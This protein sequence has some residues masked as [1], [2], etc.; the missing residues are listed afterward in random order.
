MAMFFGRSR[1]QKEED[2]AWPLRAWIGPMSFA[3]NSP[4]SRHMFLSL[5]MK[6][7]EN[8]HSTMSIIMFK[9]CQTLDYFIASVTDL[10]KKSWADTCLN[11]VKNSIYMYSVGHL[12]TDEL[13]G[14]GLL[15]C[16]KASVWIQRKYRILAI[17]VVAQAHEQ[18]PILSLIY[19]SVV[20]RHPSHLIRVF[21]TRLYSPTRLMRIFSVIYLLPSHL[22]T[23]E[24]LVWLWWRLER[25]GL[26]Y[27]CSWQL[28]FI[29]GENGF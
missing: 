2:S 10:Q 5:S 29:V 3:G 20:K 14:H 24:T 28:D 12:A 6:F 19:E 1:R 27:W 26:C 25:F 7:S 8:G 18:L 11:D 22:T 9:C 17:R 4:F 16:L 21:S 23:R 15:V 13:L